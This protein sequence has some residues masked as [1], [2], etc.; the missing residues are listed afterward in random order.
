MSI[1]ER[2]FRNFTHCSIRRAKNNSCFN[3]IKI[4]SPHTLKKKKV[5][6]ASPRM[7]LKLTLSRNPDTYLSLYFFVPHSRSHHDP[8]WLL[9]IQSLCLFSRESRELK[10]FYKPALV[11]S[12]PFKVPSQNSHPT[13]SYISLVR[14]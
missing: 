3:K 7:V 13:T 14:T 12:F 4:Y 10:D 9:Q 5:E 1:K 11:D 2:C 8:R 6:V